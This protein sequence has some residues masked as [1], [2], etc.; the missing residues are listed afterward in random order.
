[1]ERSTDQVVKPVNLDALTKCVGQI[2]E[3]VVKSM[4]EVAPMLQVL[5]YDPNANPPNYGTPDEIVVKKTQDIHDNGQVG[6][7]WPH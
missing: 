6:R 4:A 1:V 5:G 3:D 7:V 2:P